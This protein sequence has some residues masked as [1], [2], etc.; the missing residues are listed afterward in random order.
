M[1]KLCPFYKFQR[2]FAN[3]V[4][5][6]ICKFSQQLDHISHGKLIFFYFFDIFI[7][8]FYFFKKLKRRSTPGGGCIRELLGQV[9]NGAPWGGA[10]SLVRAHH[11]HG[12][13]ILVLKK[14]KKIVSSGAPWV[15]CAISI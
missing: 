4:E 5:I 3:K 10:P 6:H 12:A 2:D 7:I 15:W 11:T 14:I 9:C 8:F 13:P 1:Q